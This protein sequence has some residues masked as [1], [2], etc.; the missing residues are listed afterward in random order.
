MV[1]RTGPT[2]PILKKLI[3]ELRMLS[4][5]EKAPLWKR[6]ANDLE[7]SARQRRNVNIYKIDRHIGEKETALIPGKVLSEGELTKKVTVAAYQFSAQ[8]KAKINKAGK[9][10][11]LQ[12]LMK[13]N[14]KGKNVRII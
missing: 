7:K 13:T 3:Q 1:K 5:K 8:A 10:I 2:N 4:Y 9:A 12:E 11:T 14:P 6:I